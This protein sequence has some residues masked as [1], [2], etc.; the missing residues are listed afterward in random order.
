[1]Q[2][3]QEEQDHYD[4]LTRGQ[5]MSFTTKRRFSDEERRQWRVKGGKVKTPKG[6]ASNP[7]LAREM[8]K[9]TT[10]RGWNK[11]DNQ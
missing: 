1:M 7:E 10:N 3:S 8:G 5:K 11:N 2:L 6:F 4:T 9:R